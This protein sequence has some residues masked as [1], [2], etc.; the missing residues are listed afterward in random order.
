MADDLRLRGILTRISLGGKTLK[1]VGFPDEW[2]YR[3]DLRIYEK[4][5]YDSECNG[6]K[7]REKFV[8][9]D[10]ELCEMGKRSK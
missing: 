1:E 8:I 7:C 3:P 10:K 2:E 9:T 5:G 4:D 6:V